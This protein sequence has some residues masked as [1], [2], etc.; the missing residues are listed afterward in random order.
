MDA[1]SVDFRRSV[2]IQAS[3]PHSSVIKFK[4]VFHVGITIT[5]CLS[6]QYSARLSLNFY[7]SVTGAIPPGELKRGVRNAAN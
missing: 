2:V 3:E 4:F 6:E 5:S 7:A 1:G